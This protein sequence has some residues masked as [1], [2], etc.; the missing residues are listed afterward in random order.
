[1]AP[2]FKV[3]DE[4]Q[5]T[6]ESG[7]IGVIVEICEVHSGIQWYRVNFGGGDR[8]KISELDLRPYVA[9][10]DPF[11][12]LRAGKIDG[13]REFQ[14]LITCQ[15][16]IRDV[17]LDN[18]IYAFNASKTKFYPYQFKP[19]LKF[20]NSAKGRLL[21]ADEVGLGKTIEAGLILTEIRARQT[22][23][24]VLVVCPA[25]LAEKWQMELEKRFGEKFEILTS[26]AFIEF[27]QRYSE[28]P[29]GE[30]INGIISFESIRQ[31]HVLELLEGVSP[32]FDVIIVDEAHHMRNFGRKQRKAG[33]LLSENADAM[34][35][36][37]ATPIHLGNENLFSLLNIL[38]EEEFPD[39]L[40]LENRLKFN[41]PII[42]AQICMG[43]IP[44]NV[45]EAIKQISSLKNSSWFIK[46]PKF[47][48]VQERLNQLKED[49]FKENEQRRLIVELQRDLAELNLLGHIFTRTKKKEVQ[50]NF[51]LRRAFSIPI[52]LSMI[53]AKFYR[54][55]TDFVREEIQKRH[56][57]P[58]V[59]KWIL[60]M[61]QRR[62]ASSIPAM[63]EYYKNNLGLNESD[64]P[65]DFDFSG[66]EDNFLFDEEKFR[67]TRDK[68]KKIIE[69]WPKEGVD[70]KYK[71][72]V[73]CLHKLKKEDEGP[74]KIMVFAFFKDTL[75]YLSR[76]LNNDGFKNMIITGDIPPR[77]RA[78]II[79]AFKEEPTYE[80]LLSSRVGSEGLDFQFCNTMFNYDLPWNPMEV[81]QR[82]GR[83]DR[84]GQ[85][86]RVIRIYNF[87]LS[88]TIEELIFKRL[89]ERIGI[90]ERSVGELEMILGEELA[91]LE[92][93]IF[94]RRL[95][96][97]E[98]KE[99]IER[100]ERIIINRQKELKKLEKESA[101]FLG[102][103]K[104]FEE[105]I[106]N[107]L[108]KKRYVTPEQMR[109]FVLDFIK[110]NCPR[111]RLVY[112][113]KN[114]YWRLF[115]DDQLRSLIS[116]YKKSNELASLFSAYE[117]GVPITFDSQVAY[118]NPRVEFINVLHP[119][120]ELIVKSY[121]DEG[122]LNSTAHH[123][124][125]RTG[126][127]RPGLYIYFI[128]R[129]RVKAAKTRNTLEMIILDST[130]G[131]A[132]NEEDSEILMGEL[133]EKGEEPKVPQFNVDEK[134][135]EAAF[136]KAHNIFHDRILRIRQDVEKNNNIFCDRRIESINISF[137]RQLQ[138][139]KEQL[140]KGI[141]EG[142]KDQYIRM[143]K[144]RIQ[145]L[146]AEWKEKINE[147]N[148]LRNIE[149]TYDQ[150]SAG[151]LEAIPEE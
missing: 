150:V 95:S 37:T 14:R 25:N 88:E 67:E 98:E 141:R 134:K 151:I 96:P 78:R 117:E 52:T 1:M 143:I 63:V 66:R 111:A 65:E 84:L 31:D 38:D 139:K 86:S 57:L 129:L 124:L 99:I 68:L 110:L 32:Q 91:S 13:Y 59:E 107:I 45:E 53:E 6:R 70:S 15:R 102:T 12:R 77:E 36:L 4:V 9:D 149:V 120:I 89:Y 17:P 71:T 79:N 85:E 40:T 22:T 131:E 43:Q 62:M 83:L 56:E 142:K 138:K 47:K 42:R 51:P 126:R 109:R 2:K 24:R 48:E 94:S 30:K 73:D 108:R 130:L 7:R 122:R 23:Y 54:A 5:S 133:V 116:K 92:D 148:N 90:F 112:D 33:V 136:K 55:V 3:G 119:L 10:E 11:E 76:M 115:P 105:E 61:P 125:L 146:E 27:L 39:F 104:Y 21:I 16:L 82:I 60:H 35:F 132:C 123:V 8:P 29:H 114:K 145:S 44:A 87:Y 75:M 34:I 80:I 127:L 64:K 19:L 128:F 26:K 144:G 81:E 93:E 103:D 58:F 28:A 137:S 97:R 72:F 18:N 147:I 135:I 101:R 106:Q 49:N 74:L 118:E 46:D 100:K 69:I 41:E 121:L 140:E 20:L 50:E 113:E